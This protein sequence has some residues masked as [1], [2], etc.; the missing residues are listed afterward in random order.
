MW[1]P[2]QVV[3][4]HD[5]VLVGHGGLYALMLP[6]VLANVS[7]DFARAHG[8]PHCR[9]IVAEARPG[10]LVCVDWAGSPVTT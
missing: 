10:G 3:P 8:L 9:P 1:N 6:L 4:A 7:R 5:R 2:G